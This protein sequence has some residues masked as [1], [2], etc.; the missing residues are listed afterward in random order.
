MYQK[1]VRALQRDNFRL[2]FDYVLDNVLAFST[3]VKS[4]VCIS[5]V[6]YRYM[7]AEKYHRLVLYTTS[8]K[9]IYT[10][11]L[12]KVLNFKHYK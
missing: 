11:H 12:M 5:V 6:E 7:Q 10:V 8:S 3:K 2:Q 9:T 1:T 4:C